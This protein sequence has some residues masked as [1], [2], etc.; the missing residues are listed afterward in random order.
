MQMTPAQREVYTKIDCSR[1]NE[2]S[3]EMQ[4]TTCWL[5]LDSSYVQQ[6]STHQN[7]SGMLSVKRSTRPWNRPSDVAASSSVA[8]L[9]CVKWYTCPLSFKLKVQYFTDRKFLRSDRCQSELTGQW[10]QCPVFDSNQLTLRMA[11]RGQRFIAL[12][13]S[14][15]RSWMFR[16]G[17]IGQ[18]AEAATRPKTSQKAFSCN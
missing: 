3:G 11:E 5:K 7:R 9:C 14:T 6:I 1:L 16:R 4:P 13:L 18:S 8:A 2:G 15:D 12:V 10:R 17:N